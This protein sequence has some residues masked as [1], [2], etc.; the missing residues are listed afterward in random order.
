MATACPSYNHKY[1]IRGNSWRL[2]LL[3]QNDV[4]EVDGLVQQFQMQFKR[5]IQIVYDLASDDIYHV[6]GKPQGALSVAKV[7][8]PV[9]QRAAIDCPCTPLTWVLSAGNDGCLPG[10][11]GGLTYRIRN[12]AQAGFT[13]QGQVAD[14]LISF[15]AEYIFSHIEAV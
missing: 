9:Q 6:E 5:N 14:S 12:A 13:L 7:L 15:G 3:N 8:A 4:A 11:S 10:Q 2:R 1:T